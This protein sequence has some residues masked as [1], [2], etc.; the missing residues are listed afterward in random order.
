[1]EISGVP[2]LAIVLIAVSVL[3]NIELFK[4]FFK[5]ELPAKVWVVV[6]LLLCYGLAASISIGPWI[7]FGATASSLMKLGYETIIKGVP[8]L[9]NTL[10][11]VKDKKIDNPTQGQVG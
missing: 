8:L 11:G 2:M 9:I 6:S 3:G 1:M 7:L 4:G 5:K 10:L